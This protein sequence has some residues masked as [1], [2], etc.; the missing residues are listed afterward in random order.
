MGELERDFGQ[1]SKD[2]NAAMSK[3]APQWNDALKKL[4]L[5][6]ITAW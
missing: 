3:L 5:P 1:Q 2:V 6:G 4:N